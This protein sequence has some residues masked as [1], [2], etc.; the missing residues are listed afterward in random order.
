MTIYNLT[1]EQLD[2]FK[3]I[4]FDTISPDEISD[5]DAFAAGEGYYFTNDDFFCTAG[6]E[7]E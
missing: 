2:E 4:E 3:C 7:D 1:R 6:R 5:V